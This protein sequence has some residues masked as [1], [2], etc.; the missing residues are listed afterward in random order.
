[1]PINKDR[2]NAALSVLYEE[3]PHSYY[4]GYFVHLVQDIRSKAFWRHGGILTSVN[5]DQ[6]A[7]RL[8][9]VHMDLLNLATVSLRL[10]LQQNLRE[11]KC[12][13]KIGDDLWRYYGAADIDLFFSKYRSAFDNIAQAI[14]AISDRGGD[15]PNSFNALLTRVKEKK[16]TPIDIKYI[17]LLKQC[18]WFQDIKN[19]RDSIEHQGAETVVGYN[20][21]RIL[22]RI[23]ML[24]IGLTNLPEKNIVKLPELTE[25][26]G[27]IDFELFAGIYLGYMIWFLEEISK[28]VF[29][30]LGLSQLDSQSR[31]WHPGFMIVS[32]WIEC[33][34]RHNQKRN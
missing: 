31:S 24:G 11:E 6:L 30:Q 14:K 22:F 12:E 34:T 15:M 29:R 28:L 3:P 1:M 20:R 2:L 27:L 21:D 8:L 16:E 32:T 10:I 13:Y 33:A 23:S 4:S 5:S 7:K 9:I 19:I 17:Q 18:D 25:E 26:N